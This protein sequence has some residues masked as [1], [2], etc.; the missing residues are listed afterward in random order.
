[1]TERLYY[2]DAYLRGFDARIV[3]R[4]NYGR[5]IYLDRTAF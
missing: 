4:A 3:D 5:T 2:T 1:M